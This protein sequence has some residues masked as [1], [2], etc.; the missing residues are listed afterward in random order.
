L[1]LA[2]SRSPATAAVLG[3]LTVLV[4]RRRFGLLALVAL[5]GAALIYLT[6]AASVVQ[7]AFLRGQS[8]ELF[9][10]LT[11]RIGWWKVAW[12]AFQDRPLLGFG[13]YTGR[14]L[15]LGP[16]GVTDASSFHNAWLEILVGVGLIG[17]LP[18]LATFVRTWL[19]LLRPLSPGATPSTAKALR[20]EAVGIFVLVCF[21]SIFTVEFIW[22]PPLLFFLVLGYAEL[23][24]RARFASVPAAHPFREPWRR[25][26]RIHVPQAP[27]AAE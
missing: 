26:G 21:R 2:Q 15:V 14:F 16:L 24:R 5:A 8:P 9:Y 12:D 7:Q 25:A 23:L 20:I 3:L 1:I 18:F 6:T 27:A 22:H 19:N 11:G 17:F 4:L 13:G 10:S